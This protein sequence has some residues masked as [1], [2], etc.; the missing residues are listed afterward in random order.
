MKELILFS[1]AFAGGIFV[2]KFF[3]KIS[4]NLQE[5]TYTGVSF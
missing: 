2:K 1:K 3:W 5:N 4:Q